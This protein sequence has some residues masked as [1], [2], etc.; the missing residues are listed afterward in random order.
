[1]NFKIFDQRLTTISP[2]RRLVG[3]EDCDQN[4][5]LWDTW[6]RQRILWHREQIQYKS[7][8]LRDQNVKGDVN[9]PGQTFPRTEDMNMFML[10]HY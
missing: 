7:L 6:R 9:H 10:S 8:F 5:L 2:W 3:K 4:L 1:T